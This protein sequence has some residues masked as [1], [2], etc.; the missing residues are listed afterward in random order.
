M[1]NN[2]VLALIGFTNDDTFEYYPDPDS[3]NSLFVGGTFEKVNLGMN[4]PDALTVAEWA[5]QDYGCIWD[6]DLD[7]QVNPVDLAKVQEQFGCNLDLGDPDCIRSD[8][9]GDCQVNPVDAGLVSAEF[10]ACQP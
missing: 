6:I 3:V 1:Y 4:Q 10:G 7:G 2:S 5:C 8:I 9:D